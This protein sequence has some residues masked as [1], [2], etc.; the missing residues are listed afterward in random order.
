MTSLATLEICPPQSQ[1]VEGCFL[2]DAQNFIQVIVGGK[3]L[4]HDDVV[5]FV[6]PVGGKGAP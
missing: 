2:V 3:D 4:F 1:L 6:K 5:W